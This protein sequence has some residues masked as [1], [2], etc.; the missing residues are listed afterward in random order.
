MQT[1]HQNNSRK[2]LVTGKP[3]V[4]KSTFLQRVLQDHEHKI[5][6]ITKEMLDNSM[7]RSG[8]ESHMT[9]ST[10][11][12]QAV[13]ATKSLPISPDECRM[14]KYNVIVS[15]IDRLAE[16]LLA[17]TLVPGMVLYIDEIADIQYHSTKFRELCDK[18]L[19]SDNFLI[20]TVKEDTD[21]GW[22]NEIKEKYD[23]IVINR[24]NIE[25]KGILCT[26]LLFGIH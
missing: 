22:I 26:S 4:G 21:I 8:F 18:W 12:D 15:N 13:I 1:N 20:A 14:G 19:K 9:T 6:I 25:E 3:G 16:R 10:L 17:E 2:I 11:E 23:P 24:D 5:G 7:R